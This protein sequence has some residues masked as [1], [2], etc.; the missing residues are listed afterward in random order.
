M[1]KK[2][3]IERIRSYQ[4]FRRSL[5]HFYTSLVEFFFGLVD[6]AVSFSL[7]IVSV[8]HELELILDYS[9]T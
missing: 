6:S 3:Q 8:V 9:R 4:I 1:N 5:I 7:Q 2:R